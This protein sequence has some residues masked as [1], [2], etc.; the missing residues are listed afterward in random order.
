MLTR[1][2][3]R[4]YWDYISSGLNKIKE[5]SNPDWR[6]EDIYAAVLN[7][8]AEL[9]VDLEESKCG[10]FIILQEKPNPFNLNT[11]LLVWIAYDV[12]GGAA[13]KYMHEI[14]CI[15]RDKNCNKIEF[16]TPWIQLA[17]ALS[18]KGYKT[19]YYIVEKNL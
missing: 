3:V 9:Y 19:K 16:W 18:D 7:N 11:S 8:S 14:E 2:D 12:R 5:E 6:V 4:Q 15:A 13:D 10:S 17:E 1:V